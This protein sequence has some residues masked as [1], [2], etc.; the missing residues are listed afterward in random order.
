MKLL[1][2]ITLFITTGLH[3]KTSLPLGKFCLNRES[4]DRFVEITEKDGKPHLVSNYSTGS[5]AMM[6]LRATMARN[7]NEFTGT[8]EDGEKIALT[9][10][11]ENEL[12]LKVKNGCFA[13]KGGVTFFKESPK[14]QQ[15]TEAP[16]TAKQVCLLINDKEVKCLVPEKVSK[17]KFSKAEQQKITDFK[18]DLSSKC[19]KE[20]MIACIGLGALE[21]F[22][23]NTDSGMYLF[24]KACDNKEPRGCNNL[25]AAYNYTGDEELAH[26]TY[27]K[28]CNMGE[29]YGCYNVG[30][31][32]IHKDRKQATGYLLKS[33]NGRVY[34]ACNNLGI[35]ALEN[36]K[37]EAALKMFQMACADQIPEGCFNYGDT[38]KDMKRIAEAKD[39][40]RRAC[41]LGSQ[42]GC[43]EIG[44]GL[45]KEFEAQEKARKGKN[46]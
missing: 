20:D 29:M 43:N 2:I 40:F 15:A 25:A 27:L 26:Q 3:A 22:N 45:E 30:T 23:T 28:S 19:N 1:A 44:G 7:K 38:L 18:A 17:D 6:A 34:L 16:K 11:N 5:C 33:C 10:R 4:C 35:I 9:V 14:P 41:L 37:T 31:N 36:G 21:F 32:L 13:L 46:K 8:G 42:A 12:L 39:W 24:S